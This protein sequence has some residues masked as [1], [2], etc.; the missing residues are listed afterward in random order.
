MDC[1]TKKL[2]L[3]RKLVKSPERVRSEISEKTEEVLQRREQVQSR[4]ERTRALQSK[5]E[6]LHRIEKV[7]SDSGGPASV[8]LTYNRTVNLSRII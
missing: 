6:Q 3:Q 4:E 2:D 7:G 8:R 1:E 5:L